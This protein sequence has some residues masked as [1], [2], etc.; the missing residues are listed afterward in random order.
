MPRPVVAHV[1]YLF[2]QS[3]QGFIYFYLSHLTRVRPICLTR[4]PES[5]TITA[6][7]PSVLADD[8]YQYGHGTSRRG[9]TSLIWS[10]GLKVRHALIRLPA[11]IATVLLGQLFDRVVPWLRSDSDPADFVDWAESIV[12]RRDARIVHAYFGPI[13][14]RMLELKRR[15]GLPLVV[16]LLGDD[17]GP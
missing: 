13:G 12:R 11:P 7:V 15:L 6:T 14:W 16:T 1:N 2:F 17:V 8:F 4:E 9:L 5:P 3:T 10:T